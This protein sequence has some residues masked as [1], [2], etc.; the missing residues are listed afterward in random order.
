MK[1]ILKQNSDSLAGKSNYVAELDGN[2]VYLFEK[3]II[4]FYSKYII[5]GAENKVKIGQF[6]GNPNSLEY[7]AIIDLRN[8]EIHIDKVETNKYKVVWMGAKS[9]SQMIKFESGLWKVYENEVFVAE[10]SYQ[11]IIKFGKKQVVLSL[12]EDSDI[13]LPITYAVL[14]D[15]YRIK[16]SFGWSSID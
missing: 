14:F 12:S 7:G 4:P 13:L 2:P 16:I 5:R 1:I 15:I 6:E 11:K 8:T 3:T 9:R 10:W